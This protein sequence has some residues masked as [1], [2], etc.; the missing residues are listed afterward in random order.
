MAPLCGIYFVNFF[1]LWRRKLALRSL[2]EGDGPSR[3]AFWGD[4]ILR[5]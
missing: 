2:Y 3:Y 4:S 5:H 1:L